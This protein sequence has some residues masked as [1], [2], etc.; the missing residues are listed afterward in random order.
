MNRRHFLRRGLAA[1][2][3][4]TAAAA[5]ATPKVEATA[6]NPA[7]PSVPDMNEAADIFQQGWA[8]CE[9]SAEVRAIA[10]E[11]ERGLVTREELYAT[12]DIPV[13]RLDLG[14]SPALLDPRWDHQHTSFSHTHGANI[15]W[16]NESVA[17]ASH[18]H[19]HYFSSG[20]TVAGPAINHTHTGG[21]PHY[22]A[23]VAWRLSGE[24]RERGCDL[25]F[26]LA[27]LDSD[28]I[29]FRHAA[30]RDGSGAVSRL[31]IE[32]YASEWEGRA[33]LLAWI[34]RQHGVAQRLGRENL[35]AGT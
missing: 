35:N 34:E 29:W 3:T 12:A 28:R 13:P 26:D 18:D 21:V 24:C 16:G 8:A 15:D 30:E 1:L 20:Q 11:F 32:P 22:L 19:S 25:T 17:V 6:A 9:R 14:R 10:T 2:V 27:A 31:E 7:V 4:V 5:M 33:H 23:L